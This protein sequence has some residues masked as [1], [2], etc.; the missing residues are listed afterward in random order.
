MVPQCPA[1]DCVFS[2][3]L[4]QRTRFSCPN[5]GKQLTVAHR[6]SMAHRVEH[7]PRKNLSEPCREAL[8]ILA[9]SQSEE[10]LG[11]LQDY[12]I[13]GL[14]GR[15]GMGVVFLAQD[16]RLGRLVAIK[17]MLPRLAR[18]KEA[19]VR[20]LR[21]ARAVASLESDHI[22]SILHV[23]EDAGTPFLVMPLLKGHS[24][25]TRLRNES[26][27]PLDLILQIGEEVA[28][29][30]HV[31][32]AAQVLHRDVKPPNVWLE[33]HLGSANEV[34]VKLLDF[35]LAY[36]TQERKNRL[37]HLGDVL[38]TPG[39]MAPEQALG[40][41]LDGRCDLFSLGCLLYRMATGRP[42]FPGSNAEEVFQASLSTQPLSPAHW[43][44][45]LPD[46]LVRL[47]ES[48]LASDARHRP[49]S[50]RAVAEEL[51][52]MREALKQ[53]P[54]DAVIAAE[55][56]PLRLLPVVSTPLH[57]WEPDAMRLPSLRV[58]PALGFVLFLLALQFAGVLLI[59]GREWIENVREPRTLVKE[60]L[61][62]RRRQVIVEIPSESESMVSST[63]AISRR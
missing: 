30:L 25:E 44:P 22:V 14:L 4:T 8:A 21:E 29:A 38:G 59:W 12:S 50:A 19:R 62:T 28:T 13:L 61:P 7:L 35:G 46:E 42:A 60:T 57:D 1:C 52:A 23:G 6:S 36:M 32:H 63:G 15:G 49:S 56:S 16:K 2:S 48:L 53:V 41:E 10:E 58:R 3:F 18:C 40:G 37:T 20:F 27:M 55:A 17:A 31:A 24:L 11:R 45:D 5:C 51:F 34:R 26:A 54:S 43:K 9:P 47:I 33:P 39:Y